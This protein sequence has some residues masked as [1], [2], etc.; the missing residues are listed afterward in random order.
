MR[1]ISVREANQNFS[2]LIAEV[3]A[4][5]TVLIT[6]NGRVVAQMRPQPADPMD[7]PEWRA[8]YEALMASLRAAPRDGYRVGR[9]TAEDKYG[10]KA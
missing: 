4:G 7:D 1:R 2:R 3:E 8:A 10:D 9:I 6:K 5:E